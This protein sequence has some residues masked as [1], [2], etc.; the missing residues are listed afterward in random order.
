MSLQNYTMIT[1][2]DF[3]RGQRTLDTVSAF[4]GYSTYVYKLGNFAS[5]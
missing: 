4:A 1:N 3:A 5:R 2:G